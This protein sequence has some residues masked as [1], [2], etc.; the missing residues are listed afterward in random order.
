[1]NSRWIL[2]LDKLST[3]KTRF[4]KS[5]EKDPNFSICRYTIVSPKRIVLLSFY[6]K[7]GF[8][9]IDHAELY[10][11][12]SR[13]LT[14]FELKKAI[15]ESSF[16]LALSKLK[17]MPLTP[18]NIKTL[19]QSLKTKKESAV[20]TESLLDMDRILMYLTIGMYAITVI[21]LLIAF[22]KYMKL[23]TVEATVDAYEK[24][25]TKQMFAMQTGDEPEFEVYA[26][27]IHYVEAVCRNDTLVNGLIVY[28]PP[29]TGKTYI[30]KRTLYFSKANYVVMK[31]ATMSAMDVFSALY[32]NNGK[33]IVFDDFDITWTEEY[34]GLLKA[35]TDTQK[36]R[37]IS[38]P[39]TATVGQQ[40]ERYDIPKA[41][42]FTGKVILLTNKERKDI[43]A[44]LTSRCPTIEVAFNVEKMIQIVQKMLKF[45]HPEIDMSVKEEVMKFLLKLYAN[46]QLKYIDFRTIEIGISIRQTF[47]NEWKSMLV[48][49]LV[50]NA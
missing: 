36:K 38:F 8:K 12:Q 20:I 43:P 29:G 22:A 19:I 2:T 27:L 7:D 37:I 16:K 17:S 9:T 4:V 13:K 41:F 33:I 44:A 3:Q 6:S 15:P 39:Q 26:D 5:M 49:N 35:A 30:V 46:K 34:L 11:P 24:K 23:V 14:V 1:M 10:N 32:Q 21:F 50:V 31:G 42:I 40:G 48:K 45:I 18:K 28:G 25:L 47:P